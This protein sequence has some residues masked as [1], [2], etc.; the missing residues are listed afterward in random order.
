MVTIK[1]TTPWLHDY[2]SQSPGGKGIFNQYRFEVNNRC[3]KCDWWIIWGGILDEEE[4]IINNGGVI[5][6]TDEVH[7][8]RSFS[9]E[10]LKQFNKIAS[11][12]S[13]LQVD[14]VLSICEIAPWYFNKSYDYLISAPQPAK[15]KKI[16]VV[17]SDLTWL[18]GHKKRFAFVN[19]LIG[20]FKDK[21]DVFGRG[22]N[23]IAD[24]YE[25]LIG[26][27]Y[28]IAI[29]NNRVPG[30]FT[31]KIS[32]CFLT[33]TMPI[34]YG[35]PDI[36]NYYDE[37]S[38]V[39]IDIDNYKASFEKIEELLDTD[40]YL[41]NLPYIIDSRR[42]YLDTYHVFPAMINIIK[43]VIAS[44]HVTVAKKVK[45]VPE[46]DFST[47]DQNQVSHGLNKT[48]TTTANKYFF[49]RLLQKLRQEES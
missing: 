35:A 26:Y 29:E 19:K 12:R 21:I 25:A 18:P 15:T 9:I 11:V 48:E 2:Y 23:E 20:H 45:I 41:V 13:D 47:T 39:I 1:L 44:G 24:K 27:K 34:Y 31:E 7:E 43:R 40:S 8:Q 38:T 22:F 14:D 32:E 6:I 16:S 36:T 42:R 28:S 37:R 5:Y 17:S 46:K 33:Y 30:Y 4:V 10:F 3:N 49:K